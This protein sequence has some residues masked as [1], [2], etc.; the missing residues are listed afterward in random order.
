[1]S[2]DGGNRPRFFVKLHLSESGQGVK[3]GQILR[4]RQG[5][6]NIRLLGYRMLVRHCSLVQFSPI[7]TKSWFVVSVN[8]NYGRTPRT[9]TF[10]N[11]ILQKPEVDLLIYDLSFCGR[12][13]IGRHRNRFGVRNQLYVY[14]RIEMP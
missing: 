9:F 13:V 11:Y 2:S 10:L 7:D 5:L 1:M 4:A 14:L 12:S 8:N 3:D 6:Q